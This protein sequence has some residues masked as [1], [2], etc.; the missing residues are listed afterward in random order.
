MSTR[1]PYHAVRSVVDLLEEAVVAVGTIHR[2]DKDNG[3]QL[4]ARVAVV[5]EHHSRAKYKDHM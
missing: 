5:L 1:V 3:N 4:V 2:A